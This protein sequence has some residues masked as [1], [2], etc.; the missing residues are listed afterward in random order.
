MEEK[1][2]KLTVSEG[3]KFICLL[4]CN[5]C[6]SLSWDAMSISLLFVVE[7]R[8]PFVNSPMCLVKKIAQHN[9]CHHA[10]WWANPSHHRFDPGEPSSWWAESK[11]DPY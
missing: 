5:W 9:V 6:W 2:I 1:K 10:G 4:S 7:T 11:I 3:C 8:F